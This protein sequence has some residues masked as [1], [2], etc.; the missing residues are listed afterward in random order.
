MRSRKLNGSPGRRVGF[1]LL[2][3]IVVMWALGVCLLIGA[4]LIVTTLK[5]D[6]AGTTVA[7]RVSR[8][9]ELARQFREDV[10]GAD[11]APDKLGD[12]AAGPAL[13]ILHKPGGSMIIY[14][15]ESN[16]L[17]R[18]ERVGEK[19]TRRAV[20]VGPE[21]T[22][23]EFVRPTAGSGLVSLRVTEPSKAGPALRAELS[24]ALGGDLR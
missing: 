12:V 6:R 3:M 5:V 2:E 15:W 13:L 17:E 14:R 19:E 16:S 10:T 20:A 23:V 9:Q 1:T 8:R 22:A 24:A 11:A 18:I 21:G 7:D 4:A